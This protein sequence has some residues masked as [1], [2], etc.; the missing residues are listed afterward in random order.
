MA[1]DWDLACSACGKCCNSA[2][3]LSLPELLHHQ[4]RFVG[5]LSLRALHESAGPQQSEQ[6]RLWSRVL[7]PLR[8]SRC[9]L[10]IATQAYDDASRARC[11]VLADDGRCTINADRK[12]AQCSAVPLEPLLADSEQLDILQRRARDA[13]YMGADCI[14]PTRDSAAHGGSPVTRLPLVRRAG[15]APEVRQALEKRRADLELDKRYWGDAVVRTLPP[16]LLVPGTIPSSGFLSIA[17]APAILPVAEVSEHCRLRALE[18]A[19]VQIETIRE[20]RSRL[21]KSAARA[22]RQLS[23]FAKSSTTLLTVL[24]KPLPARAPLEHAG[25]VERWLG[26]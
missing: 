20:L 9:W 10:L 18:F 23:A 7:H 26:I 24:S 21:P 3:V 12:P 1:T 6:Q 2:P 15:P 4:R 14:M 16:Q 17:V 13:M 19:R 5:C 11:P 22:E 25:D 8:G